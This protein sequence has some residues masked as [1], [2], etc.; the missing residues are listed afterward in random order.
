MKTNWLAVKLGEVTSCRYAT[1]SES[2]RRLFSRS[3]DAREGTDYAKIFLATLFFGV[4]NCCRSWDWRGLGRRFF[5]R[6]DF[7]GHRTRNTPQV[8]GSNSGNKRRMAGFSRVDVATCFPA[9]LQ[10]LNE[11]KRRPVRNKNRINSRSSERN[12]VRP[13]VKAKTMPV[14]CLNPNSKI[15]PSFV[16]PNNGKARIYLEASHPVDIFVANPTQAATIMT[17]EQAASL[18]ILCFPQKTFLNQI[19]DIPAGWKENGWILVIGNPG[20]WHVAVYYALFNV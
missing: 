14:A 5:D 13:K 20:T 18:G 6:V 19:V 4:W 1:G 9:N 10:V 12:S 11:S 15:S 16:Y 17:V 8:D 2:A 3:A 7:F